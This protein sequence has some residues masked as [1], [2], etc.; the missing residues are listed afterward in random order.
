VPYVFPIFNETHESA[1]SK[2]YRIKKVRK[3][4]NDALKEIG[5]L[6]GISTKLTSYVARHS[7]AN[8]LRQSGVSTTIIKDAMGHESEAMTEVY[9]SQLDASILGNTIN[10]SLL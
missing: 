9:T 2:N 3:Q 6:M 1:K 7:F 4:Y 10:N 8:V 5:E